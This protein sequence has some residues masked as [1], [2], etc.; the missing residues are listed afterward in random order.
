LRAVSGRFKVPEI[1][2]NGDFIERQM[3]HQQALDFATES[4]IDTES[5]EV[6][7]LQGT[8]GLMSISS[9]C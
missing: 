8:R 9:N 5:S 2:I 1:F 6:F 4:A 7:C 3:G